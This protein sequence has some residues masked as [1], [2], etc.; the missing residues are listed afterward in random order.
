[1]AAQWPESGVVFQRFSWPAADVMPLNTRMAS[2]IA[3]LLS[4]SLPQRSI[5]KSIGWSKSQS[6][7]VNAKP[8]SS[9]GAWMPVPPSA[10]ETSQAWVA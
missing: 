4:P 10:A 6:P 7:M 5:W 9:K 2:P 1:M 8:L 3:H